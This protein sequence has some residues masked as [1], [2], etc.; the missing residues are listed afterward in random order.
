[1]EDRK[2]KRKMVNSFSL[3]LSFI[4]QP[5]I[6]NYVEKYE[7]IFVLNLNYYSFL[8]IFITWLQLVFV[9]MIILQLVLI[10]MVIS[11]LLKV[12]KFC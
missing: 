2:L 1:M 12:H 7:T 6:V 5:K 9:I 8:F 10:I 3:I 11:D 4:L